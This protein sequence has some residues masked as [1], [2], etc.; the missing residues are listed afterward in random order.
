MVNHRIQPFRSQHFYCNLKAFSNRGP[1]LIFA[2]QRPRWLHVLATDVRLAPIY[3][4]FARKFLG[5]AQNSLL[6]VDVFLIRNP[7]MTWENNE[8]S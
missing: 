2:V 6:T 7:R 1:H 5:F 3:E 8:K 4:D